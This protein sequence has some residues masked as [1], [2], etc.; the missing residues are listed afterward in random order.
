ML[1]A[2]VEHDPETNQIRL[3]PDTPSPGLFAEF[4]SQPS[5]VR[6]FMASQ[7]LT[8]SRRTPRGEQH[9]IIINTSR[10]IAQPDSEEAVIAH[11]LGH[12]WLR[13]QG[14]PAATTREGVPNCLAIHATDVVQHILIRKELRA[15]GFDADRAWI[16][17]LNDALEQWKTRPLPAEL[18]ACERIQT[19]SQWVDVRLGLDASRWPRIE[20]YEALLSARYPAIQQAVSDLAAYLASVNVADKSANRD[21]LVQAVLR[22]QTLAPL[23]TPLKTNQ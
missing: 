16:Q 23:T 18:P 3:A 1:I 15:R 8:V 5:F 4:L 22:L 10:T 9:L 2:R 13:A 6:Q 7:A 12:A 21:A 17:T 20:E 14:Y 11:E 19:A